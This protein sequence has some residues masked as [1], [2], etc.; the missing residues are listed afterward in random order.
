M[1]IRLVQAAHACYVTLA[2]Q[3]RTVAWPLPQGAMR[4]LCGVTGV[5]LAACECQCAPFC[6][7]MFDS[8]ACVG[9]GSWSSAVSCTP[10]C[11]A[12]H[13]FCRSKP[14]SCL[15]CGAFT[16]G[17]WHMLAQGA[18][19]PLCTEVDLPLAQAAQGE[20]CLCLRVLVRGV[21]FSC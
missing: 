11:L 1:E 10:S 14:V 16:A 17:L 6:H 15:P 18:I 21:R 7:G 13:A 19:R 9:C 5:D 3:C 20:G 4:R 2:V 8:S 12:S